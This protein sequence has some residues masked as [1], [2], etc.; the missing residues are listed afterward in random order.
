[1]GSMGDMGRMTGQ[2]M[3]RSPA[4]A[5]QDWL[6]AASWLLVALGVVLL[7]A[8]AIRYAVRENGSGRPAGALADTMNDAKDTND[9]P[10][11]IAQR[12]YA[13]GEI[14][15]EEYEQ[16]R[17]DMLRDG[18]DPLDNGTGRYDVQDAAGRWSPA[19]AAAHRGAL[20][21]TA[22]ADQV[23]GNAGTERRL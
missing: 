6:L 19:G 18:S 2:M 14:G 10:L 13:R 3:G 12:R 5:N 20:S 22:P 1:M 4:A 8:W 21:P 7:L 11:T 17:A 15:R 9:T 23:A 16:I